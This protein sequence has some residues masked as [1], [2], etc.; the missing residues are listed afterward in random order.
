M[1]SRVGWGRLGSGWNIPFFVKPEFDGKYPAG[2]RD[3]RRVEQGVEQE[4]RWE[5]GRVGGG[6]KKESGG[7]DIDV[8]VGGWGIGGWSGRQRRPVVTTSA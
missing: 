2:S 8:H 3:R 6:N 7:A 1:R 5:G 4:Y